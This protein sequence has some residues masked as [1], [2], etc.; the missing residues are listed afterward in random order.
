LQFNASLSLFFF[1]NIYTKKKLLHLILFFSLQKFIRKKTFFSNFGVHQKTGKE[2]TDDDDKIVHEGEMWTKILEPKIFL[3]SFTIMFFEDTYKQKKTG[4]ER[5]DD[6]GKI[7]HEGEMWTKI[8][9][10]KTFLL[11]HIDSRPH[12]AGR[13]D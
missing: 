2:R 12:Y 8:L 4:K 6:D 3:R 1:A 11:T 10:P 13:L 5:T 9:E 7:V